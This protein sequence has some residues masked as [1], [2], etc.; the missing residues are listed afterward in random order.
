MTREYKKI[1]ITGTAGFIGFHVAK[2][3]LE[4]GVEVVGVDSMTSY[5]DVEIKK[6][7][8]KILKGNPLYTFFKKDI[9]DFKKLDS[10]ISK[11]KPEMIIH[12]AAQAGVRYS[13]KNPWA[14]AESNYLGTLNIFEAA[15]KHKIPRVLF[16]SSSSVYGKTSNPVFKE[17]DATD[18][19]ISV[20]AATKKANEVLAH[21]YSELYGI[22]A[23]SLRFFTVYGE[24]GRPD[25]A[26]FKFVKNILSDKPI[27][28][29][30]NGKMQR[31]FTYIDDIVAGV[32]GIAKKEKLGYEIYNIGG[33]ESVSLMDF[34]SLIEKKVVK[35]A[36]IEFLPMQPG[37][38]QSTVADLTKIKRDIGFIPQ[39]STEEGIS[40][41]V[42][43]FIQN[44]N[45]LLKLK[46]PD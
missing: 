18:T 40:K 5:Y 46:D 1:L 6:A 26:L 14:Y 45:W 20:Y 35:K 2:K 13:L 21:S 41:F 39:T 27:Q 32:L 25:L 42:E 7:R 15:K 4:Q 28:V 43:W 16:A 44:K 12:L 8:S 22:E 24:Y 33:G 30:N 34:I 23:A 29:Y 17:S 10:I 3:F 37:D 19:P 36:V 31:N 11:E 9:A 38:V